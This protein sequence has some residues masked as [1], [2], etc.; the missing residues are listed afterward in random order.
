MKLLATLALMATTVLGTK[1]MDKC[2]KLPKGGSRRYTTPRT[3][4][5]GNDQPGAINFLIDNRQTLLNVFGR[6]NKPSEQLNKLIDNNMHTLSVF[7]AA[8]DDIYMGQIFRE[9]RQ[10]FVN[11]VS[12]GQTPANK[13]STEFGQLYRDNTQRSMKA[14]RDITYNKDILDKVGAN[15][16]FMI[17]LQ[18]FVKTNDNSEGSEVYKTFLNNHGREF[19]PGIKAAYPTL[20]KTR[21]AIKSALYKVIMDEQ[22]KSSYR[23][24]VNELPLVYQFFND[25]IDFIMTANMEKSLSDAIATDIMVELAKDADPQVHSMIQRNIKFIKKLMTERAE[26]QMKEKAVAKV[27]AKNAELKAAAENE[28]EFNRIIAEKKKNKEQITKEIKNKIWEQVVAKNKA[29]QQEELANQTEDKDNK[30]H[31]PKSAKGLSRYEHLAGIVALLPDELLQTVAEMVK[32]SCPEMDLMNID[33]KDMKH[34]IESQPDNFLDQL[35]Q[36]LHDVCDMFGL[37]DETKIIRKVVDGVEIEI[38]AADW[39]Q[40]KK[41]TW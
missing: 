33:D 13:V 7:S 15:T 8:V 40:G 24:L 32:Q 30:K 35:L 23:Q 38:Y 2:H 26:K 17:D 4:E 37:I 14:L 29:Q 3:I 1:T 9:A 41:V 6:G 22:L 18:N 21:D 31:N 19:I 25:N 39:M 27:M 5:R 10:K 28:A 16:E 36:E 20:T 11:V 34:I 12:A